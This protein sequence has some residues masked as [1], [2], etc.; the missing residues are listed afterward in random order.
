[1]TPRNLRAAIL[2]GEYMQAD[3]SYK[4]AP[5]DVPTLRVLQENWTKIKVQLAG[6]KMARY[7]VF[8]GSHFSHKKFEVFLEREGLLKAWPRTEK[9]RAR[10]MTKETWETMRMLNPDLEELYQLYKTIAMPRLNIACDPD[11]RNRL[12]LG[13]FGAI[14]SRNAPG[15]DDRGVFVFNP[16]KWVRFLVKPAEGWAVAYLDWVC[17]EYAIGAILSGDVNM[18][19]AYEAGDPYVAFAIQAGAVPSGATKN[20]H[21]AERKLYKTATLAIGYGQSLQGFMEKTRRSRPI[22]DQ[23]FR[24]YRRLYLRYLTWRERQV[25]SYGISLQLSTKPG[26]TLHHGVRFKPN[27]ILNFT[28]QATGA[29]MLRLAVIEMMRRGVR[30]CCPVHDAVLIEAPV[31]DI[32]SS[33]AEACASMDVASALLLDGYVLRNEYDIFRYPDRFLDEDGASTWKKVSAI[34]NELD[35]RL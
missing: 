1:M 22:A 5:L 32:E 13:A 14:T 31:N 18:L 30:V 15:R 12:L 34:V 8:D 25:D 4:F 6:D 33:V 3:A 16:A 23:V 10:S 20:T 28:A 19:R 2:R 35:L 29:E 11:G 27:T 26:W 21:P 24:D 17:Q 9:S 7:D